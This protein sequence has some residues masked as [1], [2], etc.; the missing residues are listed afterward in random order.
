MT[1]SPFISRCS[2]LFYTACEHQLL[3]RS[4]NMLESSVIL[5]ANNEALPTAGACSILSAAP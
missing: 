4:G 3:L 1:D 2:I 5:D